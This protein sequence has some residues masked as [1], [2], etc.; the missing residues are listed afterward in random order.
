MLAPL[1]NTNS[2]G[3]EVADV[4]P[5]RV[6][7]E[8]AGAVLLDPNR[9]LPA[10]AAPEPNTPPDAL[11]FADVEPNTFEAPPVPNANVGADFGGSDI[12]LGAKQQIRTFLGFA[13]R[14]LV[15]LKT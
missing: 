6:E 12:L 4:L 14:V 9:P 7:D 1:A 13:T 15:T 11:L 8:V 2:C 3:A 5:N 10:A